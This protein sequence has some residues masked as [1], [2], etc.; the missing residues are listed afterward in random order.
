MVHHQ[1]VERN[2]SPLRY[3]LIFDRRRAVRITLPTPAFFH[4][5]AKGRHFIT[6]EETDEY[7][8]RTEAARLRAAALQA[9]VVASQYNPSYD[10]GYPPGQQWP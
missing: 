7:E 10:F 6:R 1:F 9:V 5:H 4:Y 8:R 3:R 2:E